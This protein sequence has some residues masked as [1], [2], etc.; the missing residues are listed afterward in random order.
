M[1]DDAK[2]AELTELLMTA[3]WPRDPRVVMH[4]VPVTAVAYDFGNIAQR[5]VLVICN[6]GAVFSLTGGDASTHVGWDEVAPIPGTQRA[7]QRR[8]GGE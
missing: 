5:E 4:R 6:D 2:R 7:E 8:V 3:P 1:L